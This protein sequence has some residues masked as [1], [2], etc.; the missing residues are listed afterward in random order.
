MPADL[1]SS[2][3]GAWRTNNAVNIQLIERIPPR[4]WA[5]AIPGLPRRTVRAIAAHLH[6]SRRS[7][8]RTLGSEH[9]VGAPERVDPFTVSRRTLVAALR[10]SGRGLEEILRLG[11]DAGGAVPDSRGYVWRNLPLDVG[12]VLAYFVGHEAHHRGQIVM[13]ARQL[14]QRLPRTVTGD[15]WQWTRLADGTR[16]RRSSAS[17]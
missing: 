4:L 2:I 3:V 14:G 17:R 15:L 8:I 10:R 1:E 13:A 12:H 6:N 9:G 11:L 7:W 16:R 5:A